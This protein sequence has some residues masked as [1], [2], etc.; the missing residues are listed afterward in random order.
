[1]D[2]DLA[3]QVAG[4]AARVVASGAISANGHGNVSVRVP[5]AEEMYF[6]AGPSLRGHPAS[7]AALGGPVEIPPDLRAAALQRAMTFDSQGTVR[8]EHGDHP[9]HHDEPGKAGAPDGLAARPVL[10]PRRRTQAGPGQA[11]GF[12][13]DDP[14]GEV[15]IE[16]MVVTDQSGDQVTAYQVPMTYRA[17]ALAGADGALIGT[18]EHGVLGHRWIYDGTRDPVL[19]AQLVALLSGTAEPQA[20]SVS[21]RPDPTVTVRRAEAAGVGGAPRG[22]FTVRVNRILRPGGRAGQPGLSAPWLLPDGTQVRGILATAEHMPG[23]RP[24]DH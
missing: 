2:K 15:G 7:A 8:A 20:Q 18:S 24:A 3:D 11:R 1:M 5:G 19:M 6:T 4:I 17:K 12:R 10:V 23:P 21:S 16:F 14:D 13:L 9:R 22:Q